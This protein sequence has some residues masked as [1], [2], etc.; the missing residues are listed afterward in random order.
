MKQLPYI[1]FP[2]FRLQESLRETFC[3][4]SFWEG[5][6]KKL[7]KKVREEKLVIEKEKL[8]GKVKDKKNDVYNEK[9]KFYEEQIQIYNDK[10]EKE[11]IKL[12]SNTAN[13]RVPRRRAS[14][15]LIGVVFPMVDYHKEMK[16]MIERRQLAVHDAFV[17]H[18]QDEEDIY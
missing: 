7:Q 1:V 9:M 16:E 2:A 15:G 14:D 5:I 12:R 18:P 10:Y 6:A 3:G 17:W 11:Q 13:V 8:L 4:V